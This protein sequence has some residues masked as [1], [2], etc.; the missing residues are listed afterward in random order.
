MDYKLI[1]N[2]ARMLSKINKT[3]AKFLVHERKL[4]N[5]SQESLAIKL[6]K[7]RTYISKIENEERKLSLDEFINYCLVLK[8][9]V[10]ES[11]KKILKDHE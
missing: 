7:H 11:L 10:N 3:I 4:Q 1:Y 8:L 5:Y 9:D 2:S 6:G